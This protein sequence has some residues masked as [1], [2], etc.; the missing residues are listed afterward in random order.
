[1]MIFDY[2]WPDRVVLVCTSVSDP[3]QVLT[4]SQF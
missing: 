2:F 3:D 1:M 4:G